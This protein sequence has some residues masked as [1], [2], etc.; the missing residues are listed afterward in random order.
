M[1]WWWG[2]VDLGVW[3]HRGVGPSD[4]R[5]QAAEKK[6][7]EEGDKDK[8]KLPKV[9][10]DYLGG[11]LKLTTFAA[12]TCK[13]PHETLQVRP[14]RT[15]GAQCTSH[16]VFRHACAAYLGQRP[17]RAARATAGWGF[18][19]CAPRQGWWTQFGGRVRPPRKG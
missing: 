19:N 18:E 14:G 11:D 3:A 16:D 17:P 2:G 5:R 1:W 7:K 4:L 9:K 6:E 15:T 8:D 13:L 10:R 12:L